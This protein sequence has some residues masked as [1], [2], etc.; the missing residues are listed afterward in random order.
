MIRLQKQ[1]SDQKANLEKEKAAQELKIL[2]Q[3]NR[4]KPGQIQPTRK[5]HYKEL[6]A[7][8]LAG[9]MDPK[10]IEDVRGAD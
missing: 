1:K 10:D 3:Q 8:V 7:L 6:E 9:R 2:V 4:P 5:D